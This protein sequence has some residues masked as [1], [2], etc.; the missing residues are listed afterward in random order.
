[1]T[2]VLLVLSE[3]SEIQ[4]KRRKWESEKVTLSDATRNKQKNRKTGKINSDFV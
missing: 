1:M 4:S 2:T 3:E